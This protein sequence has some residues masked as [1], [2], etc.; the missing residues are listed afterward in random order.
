ML[1]VL[2]A[3][4]SLSMYRTVQVY[5]GMHPVYLFVAGEGELHVIPFI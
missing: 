1:E 3:D 5:R 2:L 4:M